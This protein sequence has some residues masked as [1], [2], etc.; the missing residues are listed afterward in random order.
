M[1]S[2]AEISDALDS[3]VFEPDGGRS[4][5]VRI[6]LLYRR[7]MAIRPP[8]ATEISNFLDRHLLHD[9]L[10]LSSDDDEEGRSHRRALCD[11]VADWFDS[12]PESILWR[13]RPAAL[14]NVIHRLDAQPS[15][16]ALQL[17][18]RI[19]Y[20]DHDVGSAIQ[21][22]ATVD[23]PLLDTALSTLLRLGAVESDAAWI[24][25]RIDSAFNRGST[26]LQLQDAIAQLGDESA[27]EL[28]HQC[29]LHGSANWVTFSFLGQLC[30][31]APGDLAFQEKVWSLICS[32]A[33]ARPNG[34]PELLF[35]GGVINRCHTPNVIKTLCERLPAIVGM[36]AIHLERLADRIAEI[37]DPRQLEIIERGHLR[38]S[39]EL[40][41]SFAVISTGETSPSMTT[42]AYLKDH[43][44]D[45]AMSLGDLQVTDW[46][47]EAIDLERNAYQ[48]HRLMDQLAV[49]S[50]PKLP[51]RAVSL[52]QSD[53]KFSRG[54]SS[55]DLLPFLGA[56]RLAASQLSS[57]SLRL[58]LHAGGL[59]DGHPFVSAVEDSAA[60]AVW[61]ITHGET[62]L[63][64]ALVG[65]LRS[66]NPM[67]ASVAA[68][69]FLELTVHR[70]TTLP[71]EV[72]AALE[73]TALDDAQAPYIRVDAISTLAAADRLSYQF[74]E[75]LATICQHVDERL[76]TAAASAILRSGALSR[77]RTAIEA[78]ALRNL[79][80]Q[81]VKLGNVPA[82]ALSS[83]EA[84]LTG[85]LA[86]IDPDKYMLP[87]IAII[88]SAFIIALGEL[89]NAILGTERMTS[90]KLDPIALAIV[91]RI[92]AKESFE[93]ANPI[94]FAGLCHLDPA[95]LLNE[96]WEQHWQD[97]M[98]DSRVALAEVL[99]E[100]ARRAGHDAHAPRAVA[101]L[102]ILMLDG[103]FAV[104]RAAARALRE[105]D[106]IAL[107]HACEEY[108]ASGSIILRERAA[109]AAGW[110]PIDSERTLDNGLIR[111][112]S[113]DPERRVRSAATRSREEARRRRWANDHLLSIQVRDF[114]PNS[115]VL[116]KYARGTAITRIGDDRVRDELES[117]AHAPGIPP[118]VRHWYKRLHKSLERQW[119]ETARKWPEP[120]LPWR[121]AIEN[122]DGTL[123]IGEAE[124]R[125]NFRLWLLLPADESERISWG[126]M[127]M[128]VDAGVFDAFGRFLQNHQQ[129]VVV[130]IPGR[131]DAE[132]L[133]ASLRGQ[134]LLIVG[135]GIYPTPS[136]SCGL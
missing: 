9:C 129:R 104:R 39:I 132:V 32:L 91:R 114:D 52:L 100:A 17:I 24:R 50:L 64:K 107:Q 109:E 62:D 79:G 46:A 16:E 4:Q 59:V 31:H 10:K 68:R 128:L 57:D 95:R 41:R 75:H 77:H 20:R 130:Q 127:A 65:Q 8:A 47:R 30:D 37:V 6:E 51:V 121:G 112:L 54:E 18:A 80:L 135:N 33:D 73:Q 86:A 7:A 131:V 90:A 126:G 44:W 120:W 102:K 87:A 11:I 96:P 27:P 88:E 124:F 115:W 74:V 76:R 22:A 97:W 63:P 71:D 60:L 58:L 116:R 28:L 53:L 23:S 49:L 122:C 78:C 25:E 43:A 98:A 119:T 111:C 118:N 55:S 123:R 85:K 101:L 5:F 19:G 82:S 83:H 61:L 93:S 2:L 133:L 34:W 29:G 36:G 84:R 12:L 113:S 13:V 106:Q 134:E 72:L 45:L 89:I 40:F 1:N 99:P 14:K 69:T 56:A 70:H 103:T 35:C 136:D 3:A 105:V 92:H 42:E 48:Q 26:S 110:L 108:V 94:L 125:A 21:R 117:L 66:G 15:S 67:A 38:S 81:P